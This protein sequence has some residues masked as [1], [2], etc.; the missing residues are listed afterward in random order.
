M[1]NLQK[2]KLTPL[3]WAIIVGMVLLR[4]GT[5]MTIP[6]LAIFLHQFLHFS[7]AITGI[8]VGVSYLS[9]TLG[10]FWGGA[11]SDKYGR[12]KLLNISLLCYAV[13]FFTFGFAATFR[14]HTFIAATVFF[15]INLLAGLFRIWAETL[16]QAMLADLASED[17]RITVFSLRYTFANIGT[18]IGPIIGALIGASGKIGGFFCTG[19]VFVLYFCFFN[20]IAKK[21]LEVKHKQQN[22]ISIAQSLS[23]VARD[24]ILLYYI[25]GGIFC[26][27]IYV[28]QEAILGQVIMERFH[29]IRMFSTLLFINAITIV[30]LQIPITSYSLSRFKITTLMQI[31]CLLLGLGVLILGMADLNIVIYII[32]EIIFTIGEICTFS[33]AGIFI[34]SIAPKDLRGTYFGALALQF[35]GRAIGPCL[36]GLILAEFSSRTTLAI[37]ALLAVVP[38]L[39]YRYKCSKILDQPTSKITADSNLASSAEIA[40][41]EA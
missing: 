17:N 34:D 7:Y 4:I 1:I 8:I 29:S 21:Y 41:S 9:Y 36:G 31:G 38:L 15:S 11:I 30:L 5:S 40:E 13:T 19:G 33:I 37:F 23:T 22:T 18:A 32:G 25:V 6:F 20:L 39:I 14:E 2:Y 12:K 24:K 10:G 28:Q 35:L 3:I 16:I 26:L 27:L